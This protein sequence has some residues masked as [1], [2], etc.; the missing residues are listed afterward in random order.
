MKVEK[1]Y[2]EGGKKNTRRKG[3][4]KCKRTKIKPS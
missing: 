3:K 1:K 4:N 2:N